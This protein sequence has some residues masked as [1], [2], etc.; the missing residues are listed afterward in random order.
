KRQLQDGFALLDEGAFLHIGQQHNL[1]QLLNRKLVGDVETADA[2]HLVAEK[3]DAVG[4][5][6]GEGK[7]IDQTATDGKLPRLHHEI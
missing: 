7:H 4:V 6:V 5:V 3:L 2:I 1:F